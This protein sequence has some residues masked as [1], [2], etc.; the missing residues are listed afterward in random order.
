[1]ASKGIT[2]ADFGNTSSSKKF[3]PT[4]EKKDDDDEPQY[5]AASTSAAATDFIASLRAQMAAKP[6]EKA[7]AVPTLGHVRPAKSI[8]QPVKPPRCRRRRRSSN[9]EEEHD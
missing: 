1:M 3:A 7:A 4:R 5:A 2:A 6:I 9:G 8:V